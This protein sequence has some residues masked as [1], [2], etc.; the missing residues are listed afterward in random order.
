MGM[1]QTVLAKRLGIDS[2]T[3]SIWVKNPYKLRYKDLSDIG[4]ILHIDIFGMMQDFEK[5]EEKA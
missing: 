5:K 1:T 2:T 3:V 4:K